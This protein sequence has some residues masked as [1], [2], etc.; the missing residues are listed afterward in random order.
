MPED[1]KK[2]GMLAQIA[3]AVVIALCVGGSSPWW[4]KEIF[5]PAKPD[6]PK[7]EPAQIVGGGSIVNEDLASANKSDLASRQ[8]QLERELAELRKEQKENPQSGSVKSQVNNIAG[9][10]QG[11]G[12][13]YQFY[14][15][16]TSITMEETTAPYGQTAI[17]EGTI[18]GRDVTISVQTA[19]NSQGTLRVTLSA[20]GRQMTGTYS[21]QTF[22]TTSP[23]TLTR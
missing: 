1:A 21:D 5:S 18:N 9:A 14:Q 23:Y 6:P 4:F 17:G 11:D 20:D 10:W 15:N 8:E 7:V 12:S 16:G 2:S 19:L 13:T 3:V 22:G